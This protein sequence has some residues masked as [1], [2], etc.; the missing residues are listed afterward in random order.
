MAFKPVGA[1]GFALRSAQ[2]RARHQAVGV[3]DAQAQRAARGT[4][5][6]LVKLPGRGR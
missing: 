4:S 3:L 5:S 6:S 1:L 2:V